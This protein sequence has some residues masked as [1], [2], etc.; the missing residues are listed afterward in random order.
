MIAIETEARTTTHWT[1]ETMLAALR[2]MADQDYQLFESALA[3]L[4]EDDQG[5]GL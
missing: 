1:K 4:V 2:S 3:E 5:Q